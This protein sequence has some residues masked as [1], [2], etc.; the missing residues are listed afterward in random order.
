MN[1][2]PVARKKIDYRPLIAGKPVLVVVDM[3]PRYRASCDPRTLQ[4]VAAQIRGAIARNEPIVVLELAVPGTAPDFSRTH[5]ELLDILEAVENPAFWV[6]K[7]KTTVS[8][9]NE[10]LTACRTYGFDQRH[11]R[12]CGVNTSACV[13]E[14][15]KAIALSRP[16]SKV[17]VIASA[18]NDID[19]N[20][21]K[22]YGQIKHLVGVVDE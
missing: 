11:F 6:L 15:A 2:Q 17:E 22:Y 9:G 12:I 5:R 13:Y 8:G 14:T 4:N 1:N 19:P 18:V 21:W 16:G 3:Q 7:I 20:A 10:V